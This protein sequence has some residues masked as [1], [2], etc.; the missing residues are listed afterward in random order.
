MYFKMLIKGYEVIA[1]TLKNDRILRKKRSTCNIHD[2]FE[3]M[4]NFLPF[5]DEVKIGTYIH[6]GKSKLLPIQKHLYLKIP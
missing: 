4:I 5:S 2:P 1:V 6:K 3:N